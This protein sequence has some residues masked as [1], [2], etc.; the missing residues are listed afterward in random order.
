MATKKCDH[1]SVGMLVWQD[2][3]LLLIERRKF[4]FGFAAPA[5]HVDEHGSYE[6]AARAELKEE[7]GLT[8]ISM[9]VILEGRRDNPCR[10]EGGTWHYWK[11]YEVEAEGEIE[12]SLDETKQAGWYVKD[13]IRK[14][15][16]RAQQYVD[17]EITEE[18]WR[19]KPGLE[20][21]FAEFLKELDVIE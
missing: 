7:V 4:P 11:I 1:T 19:S 6:D 13:E 18:E 17:G 10:R 5:G 15:A 21:I 14:L 9:K 8:A 3:E 16:E 2:D 20:P 12:R